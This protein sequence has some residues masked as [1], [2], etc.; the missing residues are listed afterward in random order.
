MRAPARLSARRSPRVSAKAGTKAKAKD[1][2]KDKRLS[3]LNVAA[4]VLGE[5]D[6][7]LNTKQLV[8]AMSAKGYWT[9]PGGKRA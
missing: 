8:D 1:E 4:K 2:P 5:S 3:A 9:S 7:P 6:E